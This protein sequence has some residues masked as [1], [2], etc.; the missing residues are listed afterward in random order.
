[1]RLAARNVIFDGQ[2]SC[3]HRLQVPSHIRL[4]PAQDEEYQPENNDPAACWPPT[5][6]RTTRMASRPPSIFSTVPLP[7]RKSGAAAITQTVATGTGTSGVHPGHAVVAV[8]DTAARADT[9]AA[10]GGAA[11]AATPARPA[12]EGGAR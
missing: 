5:P 7:S 6:F 11:S 2:L 10:V 8:I 9:A 4:H 12:G 3:S 1:V